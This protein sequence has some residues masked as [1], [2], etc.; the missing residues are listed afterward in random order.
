VAAAVHTALENS[1]VEVRPFAGG[2]TP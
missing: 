2:G 1:G